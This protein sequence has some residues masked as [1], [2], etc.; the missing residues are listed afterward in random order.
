MVHLDG[1]L[2]TVHEQLAPP[3][4][5]PTLMFKTDV[6]ARR[7]RAYPDAWYEL[8]ERELTDLAWGRR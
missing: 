6:R 1:E 8:T 4:W 7:V 5:V 2:W 3:D